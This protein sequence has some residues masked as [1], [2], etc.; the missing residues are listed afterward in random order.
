MDYIIRN[1]TG[2]DQR[3]VEELTRDAFWNIHGP[4]CDEH[5]LVHVMR[6]HPDFIP[7]LDFILEKDGRIIGNILYTQSGLVNDKGETMRTLTFGPLSIAPDFQRK[8]YGKA[9]MEHSFEQAGRMGYPAVVIFGNPG[10]YVSMGFRSCSRY[11]VSIGNG[12]FPSA[13]LVRELRDAA[14]PKG[15]W[16]YLESEV[17]S[18]DPVKAEKFDKGFEYKEKKILPSQEE[19]FI[20]SKSRVH[21]DS[22]DVSTT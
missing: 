3:H 1:E 9:L 11:S 12:I 14:I 5:Y 22:V 8:G 4:G 20:L 10:N 19:F 18:I 6:S 2:K 21:V 16:R 13:M 7:E 17:Y 15:V